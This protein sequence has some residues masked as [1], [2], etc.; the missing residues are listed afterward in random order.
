MK[1][2][3]C[4]ADLTR[5]SNVR[6]HM[7]R[8]HPFEPLLEEAILRTRKRHRGG[9]ED[10]RRK[11]RLRLQKERRLRRRLDDVRNEQVRKRAG[12]V[13]LQIPL[14]KPGLKA[15]RWKRL[16]RESADFGN[17]LPLRTSRHEGEYERAVILHGREMEKLFNSEVLE[18]F[19]REEGEE[20]KEPKEPKE[21][22]WSMRKV[23]AAFHPDSSLCKGEL[24]DREGSSLRSILTCI[25]QDIN[26]AYEEGGYD[27]VRRIIIGL[28]FALRE[29]KR[30]VVDWESMESNFLEAEKRF[31][32]EDKSWVTSGRWEEAVRRA[33]EEMKG[34]ALCDR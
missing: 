1:C 9:S 12:E 11:R 14:K 17:L 8:A 20:P 16:F 21:A 4:E 26:D 25:S 31:I 34:S 23:K 10:E 32:E 22:G 7:R 29:G 3:F 5:G 27:E 30:V 33:K 18:S 15:P 28:A 6:A 2:H 13:L 19:T 24:S